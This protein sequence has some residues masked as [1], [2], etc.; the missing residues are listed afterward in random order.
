MTLHV[1]CA[2]TECIPV[3]ITPTV[4]TIA[5]MRDLT[6]TMTLPNTIVQSVMLPALFVVDPQTLIVVNVQLTTSGE[7]RLVTKAYVSMTVLK[8]SSMIIMAPI[9]AKLV[10]I[11]A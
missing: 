9:S 2:I 1:N 3:M 4:L 11:S 6:G 5:L 10:S 8:E 7:P